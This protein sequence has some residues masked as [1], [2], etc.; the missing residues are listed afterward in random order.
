MKSTQDVFL[1][2]A[3]DPELRR[4]PKVNLHS[5]LEGSL[6]PETLWELAAKQGI[7]LGIEHSKLPG[8]LQVN[9]EERSLVD[10]LDKIALSYQV[11]KD[12]EALKRCAFE[13]AEGAARDGVI[14]FELRAGPALHCRPG[15]QMDD[16]IRSML[17]G[18]RQAEAAFGIHCGLIV[19]ALRSHDPGVNVALAQLAVALKDEG[20]AGFDLAGDEAG[21]PASLHKES[22]RIVR[23]GGVGITVHA[24][25]AAGPEN[26]RYAVE[27]LHAARIGH[28]VRSIQSPK[29]LELLRR[30]GTLLEVC[31]TSNVQTHAV[32]G[33][34]R[35]PVRKLY[36]S[37]VRISIGDDDPTT[38]RTRVSNELTLL[39]QNFGF[40]R[41]ELGKIQLMGI[42]GAFIRDGELKQD[43]RQLIIDQWGLPLGS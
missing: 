29:V 9:G 17:M 30:H 20:V 8:A 5:H 13:A 10:Y 22:F 34:D 25:E 14:Y 1:P 6:Q 16:V 37:G 42:E 33:I 3:A 19:A 27:V 15:L 36:D 41:V 4:L 31:P 26:V 39:M 40:R 23:D 35:H 24:G 32:N 12:S 7:N 21:F 2:P 43:L 28:G 11:L 38:S 18:L